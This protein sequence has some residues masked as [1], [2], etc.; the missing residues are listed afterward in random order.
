MV[1]LVKPGWG[2]SNEEH[3][4]SPLAK[5]RASYG[6]LT[7]AERRI[8]DVILQEPQRVV[9]ASITELAALAG[10]AESS[11]IRFCRRVEC[12]GYQELKLGLAQELANQRE[13]LTGP[14]VASDSVD[15]LLAKV[16]Q[17]HA[18]VLHD[19]QMMLNITVFKDVVD[20]LCA[21]NRVLF[22]GAG[23][24]GLA[25]LQAQFRFS[26]VGLPVIGVAETHL[27]AM[28]ASLL[29]PDDLACAISASGSSKDTVES[30]A[31]AHERGAYCVA[32]TGQAR[33]PICEHA[34]AV[35]LVA[36]R[37]GPLT[38]TGFLATVG[39][40]FVLDA[41]QTAVIVRDEQKALHYAKRI[42]A[43]VTQKLY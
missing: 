13:E 41:L 28:Q 35:L 10:T 9:Y 40:G 19:T 11:V 42:S 29:Q 22:F 39:T 30:L 8:A 23:E 32:I 24:S 1:Q 33:S 14:V 34:D 26:R 16:E 18:L 38:G 12:R 25:A 7:P 27:A 5:I 20:R 43:A 37:E 36:A 17:R 2:G 6:S 21:A 15:E 31:V 3:T 4:S